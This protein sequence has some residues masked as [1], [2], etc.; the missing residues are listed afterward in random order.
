[1]TD[2]LWRM[3]VAVI[4][5]IAAALTVCAALAAVALARV[6]RAEVPARITPLAAVADESIDEGAPGARSGEAPDRALAA[7][8][9]VDLFPK[10]PAPPPEAPA[11][12]R[13]EP[14]RLEIELVAILLTGAGETDS[15]RVFLYDPKAQSYITLSPGDRLR[16]G[17]TL[18]SIDD[19]SA[20]FAIARGQRTVPLRLELKP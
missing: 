6:E 16:E 7:T 18:A 11:V 3:P 20:T 4:V 5:A 9:R 19:S 13:E 10:P 15:R 2:R 8:L 17:V 12:A 14:P 1:M